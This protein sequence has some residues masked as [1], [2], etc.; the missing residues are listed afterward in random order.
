MPEAKPGWYPDPAGVPGRYRYWDGS[1]WSRI[2]TVDPRQPLPAAGESGEA[3][4]VDAEPGAASPGSETRRLPVIIGVLVVLLALVAVGA[5]NLRQAADRPRPTPTTT[6]LTGSSPTPT[7]G[8][9]QTPSATPT[10][11]TPVPVRCPKG[12]PTLRAPHPTDGR[13]YGGNLSFEEQPTFERAAGEP[14]F[15]FAYDVIQQ[16]LIVSRDP[17]WIAQLAVGQ[18]RAKDGF[19]DDPRITVENLARCVITGQMYSPY[20][21][22]RTD[23]RSESLSIDGHPGWL[24][25]SEITVDRPDIPIAGDHT[26]FIVVRDGKD[27]GFFFGAV[28]IGNAQLDAVLARTIRGLRAS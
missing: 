5:G 20:L 21:P 28:P 4:G 3:A 9:R 25:E 14:R 12:D 7:V 19:F 22:T 27:W 16:T 26:I 6:G 18:L 11:A 2:T 8:S 13:V 17:N 23:I 15:H 24:I 1:Q 10:P